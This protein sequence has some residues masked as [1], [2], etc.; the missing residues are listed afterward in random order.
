MIGGVGRG[1]EHTS[2]PSLY[3][4]RQHMKLAWVCVTC[5]SRQ[6]SYQTSEALFLMS[7]RPS[8]YGHK[9]QSETFV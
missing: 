8:D 5:E 7:D 6:R 1:E 9:A 4:G 2:S 3:P